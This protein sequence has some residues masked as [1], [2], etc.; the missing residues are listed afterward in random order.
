M[1]ALCFVAFTIAQPATLG[2]GKATGDAKTVRVLFAEKMVLPERDVPKE[3]HD[4]RSKDVF[5]GPFSKLVAGNISSI[6]VTYFDTK[7]LKE[8]K[9][10]EDFLRRLLTTPRGTTFNHIPWAQSLAVPT[11]AATVEH[12]QGKA[13]T[14]LV[15]D[16]GQSAYCAYKDG[17]GRWWF[18]VWF[19]NEVP[20]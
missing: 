17:A 20:R 18:G 8:K 5:R 16:G 3:A 7:K 6:S 14:W 19:Q 1:L 15:W 10:T 13:G 11:V 9:D 4:Q 2:P 12:A